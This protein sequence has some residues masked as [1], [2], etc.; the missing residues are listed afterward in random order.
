MYYLKS[1]ISAK[2]KPRDMQIHVFCAKQNRIPRCRKY[3]KKIETDGQRYSQTDSDFSMHKINSH[4]MLPDSAV[5]FFKI[6]FPETIILW[7]LPHGGG[8]RNVTRLN[9][10]LLEN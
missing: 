10:I 9:C 6:N 7:Y 4:A 1:E 8:M 2:L 5:S 3:W